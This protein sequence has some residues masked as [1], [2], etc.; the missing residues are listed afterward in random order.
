MKKDYK[1]WHPLKKKINNADDAR[2]FFH[3]REIWFC[4]LGENVGFGQDG[5]GDDF[6]RP[7]I[8]VRKFN[9]EIFWGLPLTKKEKKSPYYFAFPFA[10]G[11]S[12]A[13]LSQIRLI[14][15]HRLS[16]H[17]GEIA[18][19]NFAQLKKRLKEP[20]AMSRFPFIPPPCGE[21]GP[22]PFVKV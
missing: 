3:E 7:I 1:K 4:Y 14:D 20:F 18:E 10:A 9:N 8:V 17:I 12:V 2:P 5:V 13:I 6:L 19:I 16:Y 11:T 22:K 21:V 15:A